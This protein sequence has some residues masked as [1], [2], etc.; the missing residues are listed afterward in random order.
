MET[1]SHNWKI[2]FLS[3]LFSIK[4]GVYLV[5]NDWLEYIFAEKWKL[6]LDLVFCL[7]QNNSPKLFLFKIQN[8][9][10]ENMSY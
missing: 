4:D 3:E 6:R 8:K 7:K 5:E 9:G 2:E 1:K 10:N